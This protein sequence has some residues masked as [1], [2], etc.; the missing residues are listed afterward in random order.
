MRL[1]VARHPSRPTFLDIVF[2]IADD[3]GF[4]ELHGDR[5]GLDDPAV[6]AGIARV[7]GTPFLMVGQQKGRNTKENIYRNFAMPQPNG[8]RKALRFFEC[9]LPFLLAVLGCGF[10]CP[11]AAAGTI[12]SYYRSLLHRG[13]VHRSR[14]ERVAKGCNSSYK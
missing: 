3:G 14:L 6:V 7:D 10:A 4:A 1:Q 2:N 13:P 9:A 12:C 5:A 11:S 8:Y